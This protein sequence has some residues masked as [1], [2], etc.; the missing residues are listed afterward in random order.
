M[1]RTWENVLAGSKSLLALLDK[2]QCL[3]KALMIILCLICSR[4]VT[5]AI[6]ALQNLKSL[7]H[8]G[9]KPVA[10]SVSAPLEKAHS[11]S[12][13]DPWIAR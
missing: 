1:N 2:A 4:D 5:I 11:D 3:Y 7:E 8:R 6:R 13:A 10:E 12:V 9:R